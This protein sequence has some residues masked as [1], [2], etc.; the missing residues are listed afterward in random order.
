MGLPLLGLLVKVA[1]GIDT[2]D[3]ITGSLVSLKTKLDRLEATK[4]KKV[5]Q[6]KKKMDNIQTQQEKHFNEAARARRIATKLDEL[7]S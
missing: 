4:H 6:C 7:L 3:K 1:T 2:V 5:E